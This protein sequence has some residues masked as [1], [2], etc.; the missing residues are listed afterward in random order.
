MRKKG[1]NCLIFIFLIIFLL[2][3]CQQEMRETA[4]ISSQGGKVQVDYS[5]VRIKKFPVAVQLWT[6]R[7]FSFFEALPKIKQLGIRYLQA[8]PGQRLGGEFGDR[9]FSHEMEDK[10]IAAVKDALQQLDLK[11]VSYGVVDVGVTEESIRQVFDF[12]RQ[13]GI[14]IIV[15]EPRD[16]AFPVLEKLAREYDL[17]IAIHNHPLPSKYALPE[18]VLEKV[19]NRDERFGSCADV[20]HWMRAGRV[21][22]EALRLLSGRI[23]DV[24]LKDRS[25]FGTGG[26]YDVPVGQ[27]KANI[28]DVLAELSRQDYAGFMSIEYENEEEVD[29]PLPALAQSLD[30]LRKATYYE[31]FQALISRWRRQYNKHGWNHYGPGYFELDPR[32][33]VLKSHGGMGLFWFSEKK[34][35][36]FILDLEYKVSHSTTNSGIF[37]RVPEVPTNNDYIYHSF[38]I[39]IYDAGEGIHKTGAVYDAQAPSKDAFKAPGEWNHMQ[40]TFQGSHL[41][42]ILNGIKIIDW[43]A[44]PRGKV[45]DFAPEGYIGLQNHDPDSSVYFR[46]IYIKELD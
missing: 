39:Q 41:Q 20:G 7:K 19:S 32:G 29:N 12:A 30:Y 40:I 37:L 8:Y 6:F 15:T 9:K 10:E 31:G 43:E 17:D 44:E 36:D 34:F 13:M 45:K 27:G 2:V 14:W 3:S 38:E 11:L 1:K 24:H 4:T 21:P 33:G 23:R 28:H 26:V 18:T 25:D 16:E 42:V 5:T 46:N 22:V 35:A